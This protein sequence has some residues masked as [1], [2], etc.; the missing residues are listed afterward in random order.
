MFLLD[1]FLF[2]E[3]RDFYL[4]LNEKFYSLVFIYYTGIV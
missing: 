4:F 1:S 3:G 2:I